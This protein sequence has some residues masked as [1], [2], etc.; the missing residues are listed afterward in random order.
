MATIAG[1]TRV[2]GNSKTGPIP[3]S[4]TAASTCP[5]SCPLRDGGGCYAESGY[6]AIHW[7][8]VTSGERGTDWEM[9]CRQVAALPR[10]QLWRHNQA[11]D[12]PGVGDAVDAAELAELVRAN[13][14]RS[15]FTYTHK[16]MDV[17]GNAEAVRAANEGGF[18][19]NLSADDLAEADRL[20]DLGIAPVVAVLPE[21]VDGASARSLRTPAGRTVTVCPA[22]WRDDVTCARCGICQ[23]A[24]R[25]TVVGFPAHGARKRRASAVA[26]GTGP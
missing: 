8:R 15:G 25:G 5:A 26:R 4:I 3:V 12:L 9:F 7:R 24:D 11:G 22:T 16:P 2:S 6:V 21:E 19:V 20:S 1:L 14:G 23:R 18:T 10:G 17:P 13:R